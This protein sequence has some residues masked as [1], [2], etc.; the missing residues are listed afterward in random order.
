MIWWSNIQA[1]YRVGTKQIDIVLNEIVHIMTGCL[2]PI[3]VNIE[4][5]EYTL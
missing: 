1:Q 4:L 2:K 3:P 5:Q